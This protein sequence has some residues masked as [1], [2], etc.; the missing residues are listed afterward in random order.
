M[1]FV[2]CVA[3]AAIGSAVVYLLVLWDLRFDPLRT[4]LGTSL[5][6]DFYDVQARAFLDGH[7][8]VPEGALG[9]E[10]FVHGGHEYMYFA[11]GPAL[12][13]LPLLLVTDAFDGQLTAISMLL[14][15]VAT[16]VVLSMLVWR[17]RR[18]LRGRAPLPLWE[19][20]AYGLLVTA[21]SAG[22]VLVYL[23]GQPWVYH[24][25]YAWAIAAALACAFTLLGVIEEP[26]PPRIAACS[27]ALLAAVL[28]RATTGWAF[29]FAALAT[30]V[31]FLTG[32]H[33]FRGA[34]FG[35]LLVLATLAPLLVGVG[36]NLAKF[37]HPYLFPLEDQVWTSV[38]EHR[39]DA[40][41]ANG[42]D[43]VS[44]D[45]LPST[46]TAYFRPDGIRVVPVPP[47]I[48]FPEEP[49]GPV[50]GGFL[51]QTY[52]TGS[53]VP[54]TPAL[55]GLGVWGLVTAFRPRGPDRAAW[56]RLPVL[57][58]GAI[59]GAILVYGYISYRYVAELLPVLAVTSAIGLVDLGHLLMLRSARVQR[60]FLAGLGALVG[61]GVL[62]NAAVGLTVAAYSDPGP[63]LD[64]YIDAQDAFSRLAPGDPILDMTEQRDELPTD[65]EG[66]HLLIVGDCAGFY[67]GQAETYWPWVS[68]EVRPVA[69][70]IAL[71]PLSRALASS[72]RVTHRSLELLRGLD[73]PTSLR[74]ERR[75][76]GAYRFVYDSPR[77]VD[78]SPWTGPVRRGVQLQLQPVVDEDLYT[79]L[80]DGEEAFEVPISEFTEDWFRFQN[81]MV[82]VEP[83]PA[84]VASTG[85]TVRT[86]DTPRP[87][88]CTRLLERLQG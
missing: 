73:R 59:C 31:W 9:I 29:G 22:S 28:T 43:L 13:R 54:F 37:S 18:V 12:A 58:A 17:I 87:P 30:A 53:A 24:E 55:V 23:A 25:A 48:T 34:R 52:R 1:R 35:R 5:Y 38:N 42:G 11:P 41:E 74:F 4:A 26:G 88:R 68:I 62:A 78:A 46:L 40:L 32:R 71:G 60:W 81:L 67:V 15:W 79:V 14:A 19:A 44:L 77:F 65:A 3:I 82:P 33:G 27:L 45:L 64:R 63:A 75:S 50:G 86:L 56:V 80:I 21:V 61:V 20:A 83:A 36:I 51:D 49:V 76:D 72:D 10:A 16:V 7:L 69:L 57:G 47:F 6:A 66:E 70:E 2:R 84:E 39:R 85:V 8:H